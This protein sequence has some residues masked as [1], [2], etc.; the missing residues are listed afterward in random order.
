LNS[1][2][3]ATR[4]LVGQSKR[5]FAREMRGIV[6]DDQN[7]VFDK[8]LLERFE[9]RPRKLL[10]DLDLTGLA[11]ETQIDPCGGSERKASHLAMV[12]QVRMPD[13]STIILGL[14]SRPIE[15]EQALTTFI[16]DYFAA[17]AQN[18][19]LRSVP[20]YC[21]VEDNYGGTP[22]ANVHFNRARAGLP[23]VINWSRHG[24]SKSGVHTTESMKR[25]AL[26]R[27]SY[28]LSMD[29]VAFAQP[30]MVADPLSEEDREETML[31]LFFAQCRNLRCVPTSSKD[32]VHI[33]AKRPEI[34]LVDDQI[35]AYLCGH[36]IFNDIIKEVVLAREND[37]IQRIRQQGRAQAEMRERQ[38]AAFVPRVAD[39]LAQTTAYAHG[40]FGQAHSA[41]LSDVSGFLHQMS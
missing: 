18:N 16:R 3:L 1:G 28:D 41:T 21:V 37:A 33:T 38:Q 20:H 15:S 17:F 10:D 35:I 39:H 24:R 19:K 9:M 30:L 12:S 31:K 25:R 7:C 13:M 11:I 22:Y 23:T 6:L 8:A 34:G 29:R 5:V 40:E 14:A 36:D 32:G 27:M 4:I 26:A 2:S